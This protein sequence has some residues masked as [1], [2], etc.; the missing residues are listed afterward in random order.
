MLPLMTA[1][2][3]EQNIFEC[4]QNVARAA[5]GSAIFISISEP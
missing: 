4:L 3:I 5:S 1:S 2:G